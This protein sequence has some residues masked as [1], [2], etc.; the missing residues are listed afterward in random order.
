[1]LASVFSEGGF[2]SPLDLPAVHSQVY[3]T[4]RR[5]RRTLRTCKDSRRHDRCRTSK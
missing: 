5:Y 1:M 3:C 4:G 2:A